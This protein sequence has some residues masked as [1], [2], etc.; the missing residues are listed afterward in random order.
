MLLSSRTDD[1]AFLGNETMTKAIVLG[2]L[3]A[4]VSRNHV[5]L[6]RPATEADLLR[7]FGYASCLAKAYEKT[8]F[9]EDSERVADLYRQ[10]GKVSFEPYNAVQKAA[11]SLDAAK[12]AIS[13]GKNYAIMA[14]LE[15]YESAKLKRLAV[16]GARRR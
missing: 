8:Q 4:A 13:D 14:C 6:E 1:R 9:G 12:P 5:G 15:F 11:E 7:A 16:L 3:L 10:M 2:L